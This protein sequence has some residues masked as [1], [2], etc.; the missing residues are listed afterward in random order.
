[1]TNATCLRVIRLIDNG[2]IEPKRM[3]PN[4]NIIEYGPSIRDS[5]PTRAAADDELKATCT[6]AKIVKSS[7]ASVHRAVR[8]LQSTLCAGIFPETIISSMELMAEA[9]P[10][11]IHSKGI[12][13][14]FQ[15]VTPT[16]CVS[17]KPE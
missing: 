14:V 15:S 11:M 8:R 6:K 9:I 4:Q 12:K 17:R 2:T 10:D 1:M 5:A 7:A 13:A 16:A 3:T